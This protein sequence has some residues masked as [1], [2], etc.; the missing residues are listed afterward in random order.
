MFLISFTLC[1]NWLPK[2]NGLKYLCT[3]LIGQELGVQLIW[4]VCQLMIYCMLRATDPISS[5]GAVSWLGLAGMAN[6][7]VLQ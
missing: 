1:K 7:H 5:S 4:I 6:N 2:N 3:D